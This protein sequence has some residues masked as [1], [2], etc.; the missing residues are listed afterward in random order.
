VVRWHDEELTWPSGAVTVEWF[1][2]V[3]FQDHASW[4]AF[5]SR[6]RERLLG[7]EAGP[8]AGSGEP[9]QCTQHGREKDFA[10]AAVRRA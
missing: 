5:R 2:E 9:E 7:T 10:H 3:A 4:L 8:R 1:A 6:W